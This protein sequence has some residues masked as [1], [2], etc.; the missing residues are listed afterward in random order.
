[1]THTLAPPF[2]SSSGARSSTPP[3]ST[4]IVF[5]WGN[6]WGGLM[7]EW[8][9]FSAADFEPVRWLTDEYARRRAHRE[10]YSLRAF[11]RQLR[12]SSGPLSELLR[13]KRPLTGALAERLAD[14]LGLDPSARERWLI[15]ATRGAQATTS[16]PCSPRA[17]DDERFAL[18]ADWHHYG[19]LSLLETA[20]WR[21]SYK[22]IAARLSISET[23][24]Q[25]AMLRLHRLGLVARR[26]G[27]WVATGA[28]TSSH[29]IPSAALRKHHRQLLLQAVESLDT[30]TVDERD[31][32]SMTLAIDPA[33]LAEA[34]RRIK[35]FRRE[36]AAFL[37][38]GEA[39][40]VYQFC[41]QLFP[42]KGVEP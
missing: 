38:G 33:R 28:W 11:A 10:S 24:A 22:W 3:K 29:D 2:W 35:A 37:E 4:R 8:D 5:T 13:G 15:A 39:T 26:R 41:I 42:A 34:K 20:G 19:I 27:R 9:A 30:A 14:A 25:E 36:L 12:L 16:T 1:M 6:D 18:I 7:G 31:V 17:L 40:A 32:T 23:K 21:D